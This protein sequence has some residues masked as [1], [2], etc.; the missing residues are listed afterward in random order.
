[1]ARG[2]SDLFAGSHVLTTQTPVSVCYVID[3]FIGMIA[4]WS[5][6]CTLLDTVGG[7]CVVRKSTENLC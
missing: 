4:E 2:Y 3:R 6:Y 7:L 1:M 5:E